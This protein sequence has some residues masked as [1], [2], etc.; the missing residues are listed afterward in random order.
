MATQIQRSSASA[1]APPQNQGPVWCRWYSW[2]W[3]RS[4]CVHLKRCTR[5][6]L[7]L[8]SNASE[9]LRAMIY[10][11]RCLGFVQRVEQA[12]WQGSSQR[13]MPWTQLS[14]HCP[15]RRPIRSST[16]SSLSPGS[17]LAGLRPSIHHLGVSNPLPSRRSLRSPNP[18]PCCQ[19]VASSH[20]PAQQSSWAC[21]SHG[22]PF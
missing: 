16:H 12:S 10:R 6:L 1:S 14:A 20:W 3:E 17:I 8:V 11:S 4:Q 19:L 15:C 13:E 9:E 5:I 22:W 21:L 7:D 18:P 2:S